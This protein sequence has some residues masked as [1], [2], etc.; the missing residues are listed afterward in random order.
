MR[1]GGIR[2]TTQPLRQRR[3]AESEC[4]DRRRLMDSA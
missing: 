4:K 1:Q 3:S 2:D